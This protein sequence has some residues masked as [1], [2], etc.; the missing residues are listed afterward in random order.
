MNLVKTSYSPKDVTVLLKDL[1]SVMTPLTP[2]EREQAMLSGVHYSEMLPTEE[3]PSQEYFNLYAHSLKCNAEKIAGYVETLACQIHNLASDGAPI[4]VSLA[5]A[6]T[7]VGIL[8]KRYLEKYFSTECSHYTIS[9]IRDKGIDENA[10]EYIYNAEV[11]EKGNQVK[12]IF[13]I[14]GWTGKGAIKNQLSA[15]VESLKQKDSKWSNL[16]DWLFVLADPGS[17]TEY[18]ATR[19]DCLLPSACLNSTVSGLLSRSILNRFVDTA[20]GDFHGAVYFSD[21]ERIDCSNKFLRE[22]AEHFKAPIE[23]SHTDSVTSFSCMSII[24]RICEAFHIEDY[25]KVKP[26][27]G[28]TTRVLLRRMPYMVLVNETT[29]LADP[30][31]AHILDLCKRKSVPIKRFALGNYKVCGIIREGK[32][33]V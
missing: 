15:A 25:L 31:I 7:P 24:D 30:D 2:R 11:I 9:I 29:S 3:A 23:G 1:S 10:M 32:A 19:E 14:D 22:I 6:G 12:N 33:D 27:I 13:F 17:V 26:G 5:R 8:I 4:L 20:N 21:F 18:Y 28:E 16:H